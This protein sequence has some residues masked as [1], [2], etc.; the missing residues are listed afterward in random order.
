MEMMCDKNFPCTSE[1][2]TKSQFKIMP[3]IIMRHGVLMNPNGRVMAGRGT[4]NRASEFIAHLGGAKL[5]EDERNTLLDHIYGA[6][7]VNH[8]LPTQVK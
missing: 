1:K 4:M 8:E 3:S 5:S 7:S 2:L 6:D